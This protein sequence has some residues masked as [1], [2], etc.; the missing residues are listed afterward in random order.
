MAVKKGKTRTGVTL[1]DS[2]WE[3]L[4][5]LVAEKNR[6]KRAWQK[7]ETKSTIL[8]ELIENDK[9]CRRIEGKKL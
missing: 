3:Y 8:E 9:V 1:Y 2:S 5:K 7:K 4:E 6:T